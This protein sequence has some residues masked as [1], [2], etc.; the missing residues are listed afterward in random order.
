MSIDIRSGS[1]LDFEGDC[2][3]NPANSFLHHGAGLAHIIANAAAPRVPGAAY[4]DDT[5]PG[6][7]KQRAASLGWR[8]EQSQHP[9]IP[10]GSV[11]VT[12]AGALPYKGIIHAVGPI[13]GGGQFCEATLLTSV[14]EEACAAAHERGWCSIAFPAISCGIFGFPVYKAAALAV[15]AVSF[16]A[17]DMEVSFYPFGH[18][19]IFEDALS[20]ATT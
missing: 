11:G 13:W 10:T 7:A 2:I 15:A 19:L 20:E 17:V 4:L 1:I 16:W 8:A 14:H 6:R 3:V 5:E 9:L 18:E 12:S